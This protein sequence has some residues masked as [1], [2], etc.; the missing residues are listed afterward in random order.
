[1]DIIVYSN[2]CPKCE[3]LKRKLR[4]KKIEHTVTDDFSL[5]ESLK[6]D[7][8]PVMKVDSVIYSNFTEMI[9]LINSWEE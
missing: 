3:V 8:L 4:S 6:I 2:G 5:L 1:M 7:T 9:E